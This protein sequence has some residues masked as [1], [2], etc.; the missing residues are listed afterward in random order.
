MAAAAAAAPAH[1]SSRNSNGSDCNVKNTHCQEKKNKMPSRLVMGYQQPR[2]M[3]FDGHT[4]ATTL[5]TIVTISIP[6]TTITV[7]MMS[8][9]M[10]MAVT[11]PL[12]SSSS[13]HHHCHDHCHVHLLVA[14]FTSS[15]IVTIFIT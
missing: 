9:V 5:V 4:G 13:Y 6:V 14:I 8:M 1:C 12:L 3:S 2:S 7:L 15:I 11:L 10:N